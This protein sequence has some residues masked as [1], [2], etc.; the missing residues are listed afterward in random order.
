MEKKG[1]K[2]LI[3]FFILFS[4][5][6]VLKYSLG[7][8]TP[9]LLEI[10]NNTES[11]VP[12]RWS[13]NHFVNDEEFYYG[14]IQEIIDGNFPPGDPLC[15]ENKESY[16]TFITY[17]FSFLMC[18]IG[19]IITGN[20]EH[21]YIFNKIVYPLINFI[22]I[23]YLFSILL[24]NKLLSIWLTFLVMR[25][26]GLHLIFLD[27]STLVEYIY[28]LIINIS[29]IFNIELITE[30]L[31]DIQSPPFS[32][33]P[34][35]LFT[36]I[37]LIIFIISIFKYIE[38]I[39]KRNKWIIIIIINLVFQSLTSI[40]N[41]LV[42]YAIII[43][44]L[45]ISYNDKKQLIGLSKILIIS[46]IINVPSIFLIIKYMFYV[47]YDNLGVHPKSFQ[48]IKD[49]TF[50]MTPL[51]LLIFPFKNKKLIM[52]IL[53]SIFLLFISIHFIIGP[54]AS[55][56]IVNKGCEIIVSS[57]VIS[58]IFSLIRD[59]EWFKKVKS[60]LKNLLG[61][62]INNKL[63]IFSFIAKKSNQLIYLFNYGLLA[64]LVVY[65]IPRE[66]DS[67]QTKYLKQSD[68]NLK[69]LI[70]Y[71]RENTDTTDVVVTL[72]FDLITCLGTYAPLNL[73]IPRAIM[74]STKMNERLIR[75]FQTAQFY[76]LKD[77]KMDYLTSN[78][79]NFLYIYNADPIDTIGIQLASMDLALFYAKH[80]TTEMD[81][82]QEMLKESYRKYIKEKI[83]GQLE[84][85]HTLFITSR[86]DNKF[87]NKESPAYK[88]INNS[89]PIF[90]NEMYEVYKLNNTLKEKS[91]Y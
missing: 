29:S 1:N 19:G 48:F 71:V 46:L 31:K 53:S 38:N 68:H 74:S 79:N 66:I 4:I 82:D 20:V 67:G 22:L 27:I 11:H 18:A 76:G 2:P 28:R 69:G 50:I 61:E 59:S 41:F 42:S 12:F 73:Y 60:Y 23:F 30:G 63:F 70:N 21:A 84:Y 32:H 35:I 80:Q 45:V 8:I 15:Y 37:P 25:F 49:L 13:P 44:L 24:K 88:L 40:N 78:M 58:A 81:V 89:K 16:S 33:T 14:Y 64:L 83:K 75:L 85:R 17:S 52:S 62:L 47:T 6:I 90:Y 7:S 51:I 77:E 10:K 39:G 86:F 72:D 54:F 9:Y 56:R 65:Y 3:I 87:I 36:N 55:F 43:A 57:L 91:T 34:N 26:Y 5:F